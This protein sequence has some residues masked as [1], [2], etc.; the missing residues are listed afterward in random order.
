MALSNQ[1]S[2]ATICSMNLNIIRFSSKLKKVLL[3]TDS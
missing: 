3:R 2:T 1:L